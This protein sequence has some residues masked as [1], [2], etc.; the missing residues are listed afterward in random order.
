M[1]RMNCLRSSCQSIR[2]GTA[3]RGL[4]R[5]ALVSGPRRSGHVLLQTRV[6]DVE[7]ERG[8]LQVQVS[9]LTQRLR[10]AESSQASSVAAVHVPCF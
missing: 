9:M 1:K 3:E 10:E 8:A 5:P 6:A 2:A 7:E 4:Q